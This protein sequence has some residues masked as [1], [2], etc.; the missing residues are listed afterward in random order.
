[1]IYD[2]NSPLFR[3]FLS[4]KGGADKRLFA[5]PV[6]SSHEVNQ[7]LAR[8]ASN[9]LATLLTFLFLLR[10]IAPD[11]RGTACAVLRLNPSSTSA[12]CIL[13]LCDIW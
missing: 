12:G 9:C 8:V 5:P 3:S 4:Q 1:M 13:V 7:T 10:S 2:V 6:L 11:S